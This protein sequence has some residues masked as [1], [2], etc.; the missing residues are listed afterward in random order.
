MTS[1]VLT[2]A[3]ALQKRLGADK[4]VLAVDDSLC[5]KVFGTWKLSAVR[6]FYDHVEQRRQTHNHSNASRYIC[7]ML[8]LGPFSFSLTWRLSLKRGQVSKLRCNGHARVTFLTTHQLVEQMPKEVDTCLPSGQVYVL[9]DSWHASQVMFKAVRKRG[10]HLVCASRSNRLL[11]GV[12]LIQLWRKLAQQRARRITLRSTKGKR[13]CRA[14]ITCGR[15]RS[16]V[17]DVAVVITKRHRL[18]LTPAYFM[19]SDSALSATAILKCYSL[20]LNC[21]LGNW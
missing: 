21:E 16:C 11:S 10:R 4:I 14:R 19:S 13:S 6:L 18:D 12:P 2:A 15:V 8:V 20:R 17:H 9:L 7:L 1:A 5:V 3:G